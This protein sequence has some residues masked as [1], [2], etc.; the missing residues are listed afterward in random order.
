MRALIIMK[1]TKRLKEMKTTKMMTR[2]KGLR[3]TPNKMQE[4]QMRALM[5]T[6]MITK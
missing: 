4:N 6:Q 2:A 1:K 3:T 5:I